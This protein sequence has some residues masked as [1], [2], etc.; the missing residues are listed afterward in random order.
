[1]WREHPMGRVY[2]QSPLSCTNLGSVDLPPDLGTPSD[3]D[4]HGV[5]SFHVRKAVSGEVE[6]IEWV[7]RR[8]SPLLLAH[9]E[10]RLKS[11]PG[12]VD[13]E[14]LVQ[15]T[16]L[17]TLPR[18]DDIRP[19]DGRVTPVLLRFMTTVVNRRVRDLLQRAVGRRPSAGLDAAASLP[20]GD[21]SVVTR[22]VREEARDAVWD[23]LQRLGQA[24][25]EVV[26]LRGI[27]QNSVE[28]VAAVVQASPEAARKRYRRALDQL[29][30]LLPESVFAELPDDV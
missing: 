11:L 28:A 7:V 1:M 5:T 25:R 9:A 23:A 3:L 18:L 21:S 27:E 29:R 24:D 13:P 6:S 19:R 30:S 14:D 22:A 10:Y 12:V 15:D 17:R 4:P 16:W 2:W 26:V 8:L 20:A